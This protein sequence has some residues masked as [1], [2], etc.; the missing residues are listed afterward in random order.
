[1]LVTK[2]Q[3]WS[4]TNL[5]NKDV[6]GFKMSAVH[7]RRLSR[8]GLDLYADLLAFLGAVN[9]FV[10]DLDARHHTDVYKLKRTTEG[11]DCCCCCHSA[12]RSFHRDRG[13]LTYSPPPA[14]VFRVSHPFAGYAD[15]CPLPQDTG[16][17]RHPHH[18]WISGVKDE[19]RKN[20]QLRWKHSYM[21]DKT[22]NKTCQTKSP[23]ERAD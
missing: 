1:M 10:V 4:C 8:N 3:Q 21:P 15:W 22:K 17:H 23:K 20:S 13:P 19:L 9:R 2:R 16:F 12:E 14:Q 11:E 18:D 5:A 7:L 6:S